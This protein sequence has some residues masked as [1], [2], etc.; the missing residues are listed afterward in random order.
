MF[1]QG[2]WY[3][4]AVNLAARLCAAAQPGHLLATVEAVNMLGP[5]AAANWNA[6]A[7]LA[8]KRIP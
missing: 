8:L 1:D 5:S 4:A 3:G 6:Q 7:S 2:D